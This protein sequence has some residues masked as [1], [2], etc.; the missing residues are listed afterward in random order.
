MRHLQTEYTVVIKTQPAGYR[1]ET[2]CYERAQLIWVQDGTLYIKESDADDEK[3]LTGGMFALLRGGVAFTLHCTGTGYNGIGVTVN[4]DLPSALQ[5]TP[6]T[7]VT[8]S[9]LRS[10]KA[11]LHRHLEAPLPESGVVLKGLGQ[12]LV[13]ETLM[14]ARERTPVAG[15]DWA[16]SVRTALDINLGTGLN[17][18]AALAS[19]PLSYRQLSRCFCEHF[20]ISPKAYH[21]QL[22]I[23]EARRLLTASTLDI[24]AI[25]YE[26]GFSSSQ[27]F[28]VRFR[29]LVG[30]PPS[31]YRHRTSDFRVRKHSPYQHRDAKGVQRQ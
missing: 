6:L 30:C 24:T 5:G 29:A 21:E 28:A 16:E 1:F 14:L 31:A 13:W 27:H 20:G 22:R 11:L 12:A 10:L 4:G 26:L 17:I 18:R 7:G 8:D 23:N 19:L 25:A 15:R 9:R 3:P 2:R